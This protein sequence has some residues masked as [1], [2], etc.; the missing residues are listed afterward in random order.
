M[1]SGISVS[2]ALEP[3]CRI[4]VFMSPLGPLRTS[5]II[6][7]WNIEVYDAIATV[8]I[9][10]YS[11]RDLERGYP[12]QEGL[13]ALLGTIRGL[14]GLTRAYLVRLTEVLGLGSSGMVDGAT[15][16]GPQIVPKRMLLIYSRPQIV[17]HICICTYMK[18]VLYIS[19]YWMCPYIYIYIT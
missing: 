15:T 6:L 3:D 4:L 8:G 10:S 18:C 19:S 9:S 11:Y 5:N 12:N 2:W 7:R 17:S 13:L 16:V 14:L 1:A